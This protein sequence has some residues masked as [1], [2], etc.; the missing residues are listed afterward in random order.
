MKPIVLF[1]LIISA[2]SAHS[3]C[4]RQQN[5]EHSREYL[6]NSCLINSIGMY[7]DINTFFNNRNVWNNVLVFS[8]NYKGKKNAHAVTVF[9]WNNKYYAYDINQGSWQLN[10]SIDLKNNPLLAARLICPNYRILQASYLVK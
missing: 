2:F 8:F 5:T 1:L 4:R 3:Q 6:P 9:K 10:S 7:E